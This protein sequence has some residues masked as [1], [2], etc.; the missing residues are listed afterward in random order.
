MTAP[1]I[2]FKVFTDGRSELDRLL[3]DTAR[4]WLKQW[5]ALGY[6]SIRQLVREIEQATGL[7]EARSRRLLSQLGIQLS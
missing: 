4:K 3:V 2:A 1:N 6:P 7:D 5:A